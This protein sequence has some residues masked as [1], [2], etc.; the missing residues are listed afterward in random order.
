MRHL[1]PALLALAAPA[2]ALAQEPPPAGAPEPAP[3]AEETAARLTQGLSDA[4]FSIPGQ[5][6]ADIA[7]VGDPHPVEDGSI[8]IDIEAL[9][10]AE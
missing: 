5:I 4:E 9:T 3:G 10:I 8:G 7:V 6:V 1:A 2:L